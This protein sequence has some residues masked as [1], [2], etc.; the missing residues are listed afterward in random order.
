MLKKNL[1]IIILLTLIIFPRIILGFRNE[2]LA[3]Q[4]AVEVNLGGRVRFDK[5]DVY[6]IPYLEDTFDVVLNINM[7]HLVDNPIQMLNEIERILI[8]GGFLYIAD[9][10]RSF[11]GLFDLNRSALHLQ[12]QQFLRLDRSRITL[13]LD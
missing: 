9:L 7:V 5:A 2:K 1:I 3:R 4:A 12:L 6:Q 11:L 13:P 8:P 10:R